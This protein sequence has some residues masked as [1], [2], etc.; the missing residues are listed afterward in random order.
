MSV[1]EPQ[2]AGTGSPPITETL[3]R[4]TG[5]VFTDRD[6]ERGTPVHVTVTLD[7]GEQIAHG[8]G[9]VELVADRDVYKKVE[10]ER[11]LDHAERIHTA[12]VS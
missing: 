7:T 6:L 9:Q 1:T 5:A 10:G 11:V 2:A 3:I 8:Y 4:F 12:K